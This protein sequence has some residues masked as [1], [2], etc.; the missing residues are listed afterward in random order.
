MVNNI[1]RFVLEYEELLKCMLGLL[2]FAVFFLVVLRMSRQIRKTLK[3]A[4]IKDG[5]I[6]RDP[7][8]EEQYA[9][10]RHF[11]RMPG[12][13]TFLLI[14]IG[15]ILVVAAYLFTVWFVKNS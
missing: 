5:D 10:A 14:I 2:T 12:R 11:S 13:W 3:S 8:K 1:L 9:I 4:K 6:L 7:T 15:I